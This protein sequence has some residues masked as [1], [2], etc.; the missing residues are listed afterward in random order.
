[1]CLTDLGTEPP[2]PEPTIQAIKRQGEEM[3]VPQN[4]R[5]MSHDNYTAKKWVRSMGVSVWLNVLAKKG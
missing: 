1:M 3:A 2:Q 5:D 4:E